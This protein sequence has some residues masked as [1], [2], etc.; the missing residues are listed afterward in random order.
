MW[1]SCFC[2]QYE[3]FIEMN[4]GLFSARTSVFLL[5]STPK[6][7][8]ALK[9]QE[10]QQILGSSGWT[11]GT[12]LEGKG[13]DPCQNQKEMSSL[14]IPGGEA[15]HAAQRPTSTGPN[16]LMILHVDEVCYRAF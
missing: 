14:L 6:R 13:S 1:I 8:L 9:E 7:Y 5:N 10:P 11:Y 4:I 15:F 2:C 12:I 3:I 16:T